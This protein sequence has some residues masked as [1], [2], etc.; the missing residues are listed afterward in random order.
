MYI[1]RSLGSTAVPAQATC[2]QC[3]YLWEGSCRICENG[4][5]HPGCAGCTDGAPRRAPWYKSEFAVSVASATL[6]ALAVAMLV[7][8][9]EGAIRR[10]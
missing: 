5:K 3:S 9:I 6:V 7:P 1:Y 2:P 4:D 8:R 10:K